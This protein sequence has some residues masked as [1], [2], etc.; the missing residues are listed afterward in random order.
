M[1]EFI[2]LEPLKNMGQLEKEGRLYLDMLYFKQQ[3][4]L[5]FIV[6]RLQNFIQRKRVKEN[7][8]FVP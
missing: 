1:L 3:R 4:K 8:Q 7:I 5:V 2:N 6:L